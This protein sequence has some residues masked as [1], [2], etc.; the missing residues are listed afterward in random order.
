MRRVRRQSRNTMRIPTTAATAPDLIGGLIRA[1]LFQSAHVDVLV[2][3]DDLLGGI[4]V[5]HDN[6]GPRRLL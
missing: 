6:Q 5:P 1:G 4:S 2:V 3:L